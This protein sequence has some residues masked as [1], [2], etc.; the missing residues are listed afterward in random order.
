VAPS[1][2]APPRGESGGSRGGF[3]STRTSGTGWGAS[4]R[5]T[6]APASG[7]R[8]SSPSSRADAWSPGGT[9]RLSAADAAFAEKA[10]SAG[11]AY[12]SRAEAVAAFRDR[13]AR[14]YPTRYE[15]EPAAR[16]S[17]IPGAVVVDNRR[18]TV[19]Y[20]RGFG[21]YGYYVGSRWYDYDL[22]DDAVV[23]ASVMHRRGYLY[24]AYGDGL[25]YAP[26]YYDYPHAVVYRSHSGWVA[27]LVVI[28]L[29]VAV[30][31]VCCWLRAIRNAGRC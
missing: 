12:A 22:F 16:P 28:G 24:P 25:P 17:H 19:V 27:F 11:T 6:P 15:T 1:R 9:S 29:V 26:A 21:G 14:E 4:V 10:K 7:S 5:S 20:D 8:W 18:Y 13:H 23:L 31:A 2:A 3:S 30:L